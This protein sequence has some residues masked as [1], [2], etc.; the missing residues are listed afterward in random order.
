MMTTLDDTAVGRSGRRLADLFGWLFGAGAFLL[1]SEVLY[2]PLKV[3][4]FS[5]AGGA[6]ADAFGSFAEVLVG[7]LPTAALLG[8]MW[9]A[10]ALFR[11]FEGGDVLAVETSRRLSRLGDWLVVS[12]VLAILIAPTAP[13]GLSVESN[14]QGLLADLALGCVGLAIRLLG[15]VFSSAAAI[16]AE[17]DQII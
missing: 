2:R 1:V 17:H 6:S 7:A 13:G 16:K 4:G 5:L 8:A 3:F 11:G 9:S 14:F 15:R 10:R 12:A